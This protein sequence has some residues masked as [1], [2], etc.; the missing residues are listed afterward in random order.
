MKPT[1]IA[2]A[3]SDLYGWMHRSKS[4]GIDWRGYILAGGPMM[5]IAAE[6]TQWG[7]LSHDAPSLKAAKRRLEAVVK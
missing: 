6:P 5:F 7:G 2:Q 3:V 4:A 1:P